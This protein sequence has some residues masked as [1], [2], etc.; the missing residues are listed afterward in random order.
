M[1]FPIE[2]DLCFSLF[3]SLNLNRTLF[4][5]QK[6]GRPCYSATAYHAT[7]NSDVIASSQCFY[8]ATFSL[9]WNHHFLQ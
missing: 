8:L 5:T 9:Y 7:L 6:T 4:K 3:L 1:Y 2:A